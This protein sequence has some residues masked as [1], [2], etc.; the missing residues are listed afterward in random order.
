MAQVLFGIWYRLYK[1]NLYMGS[2][3]VRSCQE[4]DKRKMFNEQDRTR[5]VV[6][7]FQKPI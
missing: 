2:E 7:L 4:H 5:S 6:G 3:E 1:W